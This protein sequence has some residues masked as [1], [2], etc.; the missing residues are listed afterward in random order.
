MGGQSF[1]VVCKQ[2]EKDQSRIPVRFIL[3]QKII[4]TADLL[5]PG[6]LFGLWIQIVFES[7]SVPARVH[8]L[9]VAIKQMGQAADHRLFIVCG[10][11]A[12][13]VFDL[14]VYGRF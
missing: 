10:G 8:R 1:G 14:F 5:F 4:D 6:T 9:D 7:I 13:R 12:F 3:K 2:D 11:L